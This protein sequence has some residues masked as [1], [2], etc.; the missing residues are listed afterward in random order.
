MAAFIIVIVDFY[1]RNSLFKHNLPIDFLV[2]NERKQIL[3]FVAF[4]NSHFRVLFRS[5]GGDL[6]DLL[7][8]L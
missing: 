7:S 5:C 3:P 4:F 8:V 2:C 1:N 6:S